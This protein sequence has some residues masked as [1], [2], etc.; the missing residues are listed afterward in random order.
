VGDFKAGKKR[1]AV[2]RLMG[3]I[4]TSLAAVTL[5]APNYEILVVCLPNLSVLHFAGH[6]IFFSLS[7][8]RGAFTSVASPRVIGARTGH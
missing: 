7:R 8:L 3:A 5:S 2:H 4:S 1:E 6:L